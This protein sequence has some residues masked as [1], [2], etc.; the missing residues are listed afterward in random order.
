VKGQGRLSINICRAETVFA[1]VRCR[2]F[3]CTVRILVTDMEL[4]MLS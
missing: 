4:P 1:A 3:F 2:C